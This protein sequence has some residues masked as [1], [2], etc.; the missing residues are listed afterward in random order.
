MA[1]RALKYSW[2][3]IRTALPKGGW[4]QQS[5]SSTC[6]P[7]THK[8]VEMKEN[9]LFCRNVCVFVSAIPGNELVMLIEV[10]DE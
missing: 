1:T 9:H 6:D 7:L 3:I 10:S 2:L 5:T 4:V 8:S